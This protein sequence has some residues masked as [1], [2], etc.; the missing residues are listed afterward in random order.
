MF[1]ARD[2]HQPA[3]QERRMRRF[4]TSTL[5]KA[6][7]RSGLGLF[8]SIV[9]C[10]RQDLP[11]PTASAAAP[12]VAVPGP[13][14]AAPE[15]VRPPNP[16]VVYTREQFRQALS[17]KLDVAQVATQQVSAGDGVLHVPN[18]WATH[19]MVAVRNPDGTISRHC[20]SSSAEVTALMNRTSS[21]VEP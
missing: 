9:G 15:P 2:T 12:Q 14:A 13:A 11:D 10:T 8:L 6:I 1:A 21:G 17:R 19:A 3:P 16:R 20:V 18:G 5:T 4:G 7:L